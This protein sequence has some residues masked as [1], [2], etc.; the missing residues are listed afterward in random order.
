MSQ[1]P[2]AIK[3]NFNNGNP[4]TQALAPELCTSNSPRYSNGIHV[5]QVNANVHVCRSCS[6][7][8]QK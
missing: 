7:Q 1:S 6:M 2:V 5:V 3:T 4:E 8:A